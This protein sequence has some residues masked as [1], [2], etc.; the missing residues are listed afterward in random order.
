[1]PN[2]LISICLPPL[3]TSLVFILVTRG[4]Y[5]VAAG[6][7]S[8]LA[9]TWY[10][11][12]G[13]VG[14]S[15]WFN[16]ALWHPLELFIAANLFVYCVVAATFLLFVT[17]P[18]YTN[19][20]NKRL[21]AG[22][23]TLAG[24]V[25]LALVINWVVGSMYPPPPVM[26]RSNMP[27]H[28]LI[29]HP[30][31]GGIQKPPAMRPIPAAS[32][33]SPPAESWL[34]KPLSEDERTKRTAGD[35]LLFRS[36]RLDDNAP[37]NLNR[38]QAELVNKQYAL[39]ETQLDA[40]LAKVL[41][42]PAY[43]LV[44]RD[45]SDFADSQ[46]PGVEVLNKVSLDEWLK[47][48]PNNPWA[49]YSAGL[50]LLYKAWDARGQHFANDVTADQWQKMHKYAVQARSE[51]KHALKLNP[52]LAM[53]WLMLMNV[54][55]LDGTASDVKRD[56][57]AAS[58]QRPASLLIPDQYENTLE[59]RWGGSYEQM[60]A[61]ARSRSTS[62]DS[63]PRLWALMGFASADKGYSAVDEHCDPCTSHQWE[64]SLKYYNAALRYEDYTS[65]LGRAG[66]A[67]AHVHRYA[68]AYKYFERAIKYRP[69]KFD[70]TV[71]MELMQA[72]C[73]PSYDQSKLEELRQGAA[74]YAGIQ[75]MEYPRSQGDCTYYQAELPW[76]DEPIPNP[77]TAP[78]YVIESEAPTSH[79]P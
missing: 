74:N 30:S 63:N 70:W 4:R 10:E 9:A 66:D 7:L 68:L 59:P 53:A 62:L 69:G 13:V 21:T 33:A 58:K 27:A 6:A 46:M 25:F 64:L 44:E 42:D 76:D 47:A 28:R 24:L 3:V 49:H 56:Y 60:D 43:D 17:K 23:Y 51:L 75:A 79:K 55:N 11:G 52:K 65:W 20:S 34:P 19:V 18:V 72:L 78:A 73:D 38:L 48:S 29:P 36:E 40:V 54:D 26:A 77:G 50:Y 8:I 15:D 41:A 45:A 12:V 31:Q 16:P 35:Q 2:D 67:A 71:Q 5:L 37:A 1:M 22:L 61:V 32:T 39:V 14:S 57:L